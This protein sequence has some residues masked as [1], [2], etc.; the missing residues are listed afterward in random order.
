ML[1][2]FSVF[3]KILSPK[4]TSLHG[5]TSY[6]IQIVKIGPL[7]QPVR[8]TKRPRKKKETLLWQTGYSSRP[9]TWG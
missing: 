5:K 7:L 4:E 2:V 8:M 9:L 3:K 6:Y 1:M